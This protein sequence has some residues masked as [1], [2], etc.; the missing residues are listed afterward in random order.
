MGDSRL[1]PACLPR[2]RTTG[3]QACESGTRS[4][5]A[6]QSEMASPEHHARSRAGATRA[7]R[8]CSIFVC[9][10]PPPLVASVSDPV[11]SRC[12][13][14]PLRCTQIDTLFSP[15]AICVAAVLG[16]ALPLLS[17]YG[18]GYTLRACGPSLRGK[19]GKGGSWVGYG[20]ERLGSEWWYIWR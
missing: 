2:S 19:L 17:D 10:F 1:V 9:F 13:R 15:I 11:L 18:S 7:A 8:S 16:D 20:R 14:P 12:A 6:R 5:P 4:L 3:G